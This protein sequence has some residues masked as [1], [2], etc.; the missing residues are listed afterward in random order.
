MLIFT[1]GRDDQLTLNGQHLD[2]M[3]REAQ[4]TRIP[5]YMIRT[6]HKL[7]LG[8]VKQDAI[9]QP[10]ITRTGGRFYAAPDEA[11]I[12]KAL[13][14][15]DRLSEGRID[16]RE[17]TTQRPRFSGYALF[18]VG[19]WLTAGSLKLGLPFFSTFP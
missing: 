16:I 11:S 13:D 17:Y 15:I 19:L 6:A 14:E 10:A 2:N 18:A 1:D 9:W 3:V 8:E 12:L 4:R 7:K 5:M